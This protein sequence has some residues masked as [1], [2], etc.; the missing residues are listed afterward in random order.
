MPKH[1]ST[2]T[3]AHADIHMWPTCRL[4]AYFA[5]LPDVDTVSPLPSLTSL[6]SRGEKSPRRAQSP[7]PKGDRNL[8]TL[9]KTSDVDDD[10]DGASS[11]SRSPAFEAHASGTPSAVNVEMVETQL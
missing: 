3:S 4:P 7:T 5:A 9:M 2:R 10:D 11:R 1:M 8:E 6:V